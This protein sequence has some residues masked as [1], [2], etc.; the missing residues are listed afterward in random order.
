MTYQ[1]PA[2]TTNQDVSVTAT[3]ATVDVK[4]SWLSKINWTQ[5]VGLLA[6]LLALKGITM[7]P[8]TQVQVVVGIQAVVAAVTWVFKTFFTSTVTQ[9]SLGVAK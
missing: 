6:T 7:S 8:E 1:P 4:S 3:T 2:P 9:S 5:A